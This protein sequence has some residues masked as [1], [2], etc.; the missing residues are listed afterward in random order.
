M[1]PVIGAETRLVVF[2]VPVVGTFVICVVGV[3]AVRGTLFS[4][5]SLE[6]QVPIAAK[7]NRYN[8]NL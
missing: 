8:L 1:A 7:A 6:K 4:P 3:V 5:A 2:D